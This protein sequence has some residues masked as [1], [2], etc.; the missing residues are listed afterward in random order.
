MIGIS[1]KGVKVMREIL[2][3]IVLDATLSFSKVYAQV[4]YLLEQI[5]YDIR[6]RKK[7]E[8][9]LRVTYSITLLHDRP[10]TVRFSEDFY[11]RDEQALLET[12]SSISFSGGSLDGREALNQ[13]IKEELIILNQYHP[14]KKGASLRRALLVLTDSIPAEG[15]MIPDFRKELTPEEENH[16]LSAAYVYSYSD[17]YL[18]VFHMVN[19]TGSL[20]ENDRYF[21]RYGNLADL[22][23]YNEEE[24]VEEMKKLTDQILSELL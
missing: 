23:Q 16:G 8:P 21:C 18:P 24:S 9:D 15:E 14:E 2:F 20:T 10:E 13:A 11:C 3:G 5:L 7:E 12:L 6:K 22:L 19:P 17:R 4:Y 1:E